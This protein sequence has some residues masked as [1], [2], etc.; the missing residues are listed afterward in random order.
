VEI[1][2]GAF[3]LG[4]SGYVYKFRMTSDLIEAVEVVSKDGRFVPIGVRTL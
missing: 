1:V 2:R 4:A 3:D